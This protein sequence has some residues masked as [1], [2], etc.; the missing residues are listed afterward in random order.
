MDNFVINEEDVLL[1]LNNLKI[2]ESPD[3]D[4]IHPRVLKE[5]KIEI[6]DFLTKLFNLSLSTGYLP[7]DWTLSTVTAI[8]KKDLNLKFLTIVQIH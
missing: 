1:N 5:V 7:L 3:I 6:K 4:N 2:D 8:L